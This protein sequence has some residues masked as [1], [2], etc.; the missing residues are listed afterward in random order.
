MASFGRMLLRSILATSAVAVLAAPAAAGAQDPPV[1]GG[2][3]LVAKV[4]SYLELVLT[5]PTKGFPAFSKPGSFQA[6]FSARVTASD[7]V[8]LLSIADGDA[9]SGAKL[10]HIS[11]G[12]KRL[13]AALE[14]T[15]GS[16]AFQP[17]DGSVDPR[18][19]RWTDAVSR[20]PATVKLRQ[21]LTG[22]ATGSYRKVVLVTLS[23]ET[24]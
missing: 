1:D 16:A 22:K 21:K 24:P 19:S 6:S 12:S 23:A 3:Q 2:T 14:A 15:V 5:Q 4:P 13:P 17:L 9:V 7:S 11:V 10:G 20:K 8:T 18:L